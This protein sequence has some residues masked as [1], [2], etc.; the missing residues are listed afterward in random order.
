M[1]T[2]WMLIAH[3]FQMITKRFSVILHAIENWRNQMCEAQ[4]YKKFTFLR[5]C[6]VP[7]YCI[8]PLFIFK[9]DCRMHVLIGDGKEHEMF[10]WEWAFVVH[11]VFNW[12]NSTPIWTEYWR[13]IDCMKLSFSSIHT[14]KMRLW[15]SLLYLSTVCSH[16]NVTLSYLFIFLLH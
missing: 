1:R 15:K 8:S 4:P 3:A 9:W 12:C 16:S 11:K 5:C 10:Y 6:T 13:N 7:F 2:T 14:W